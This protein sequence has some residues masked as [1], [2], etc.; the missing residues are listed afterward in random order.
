MNESEYTELSFREFVLFI[1]D[2]LKLFLKYWWAFLLVGVLAGAIAYYVEKQ[3]YILFLAE[4][5]YVV[6]K[7][8]IQGGGFGSLLGQFGISKG[9]GASADKII[10]ISQSDMIGRSL[11][12]DSV[13]I[14]GRSELLANHII[15]F[16]E[17][18]NIWLE[19]NEPGNWI[20]TKN[21]VDDLSLKERQ[22]IKRLV[23]MLY[24]YKNGLLFFEA[25]GVSGIL[26]IKAMTR[27]P[28]LSLNLAYMM[29][30]KIQ[31]FYT[32]ESVGETED[33][34][35]QLEAKRDSIYTVLLDKEY[36]LARVE[37]RNQNILSRTF[38]VRRAQ[39]NREVQYLSA[40]YNETL[41][42][43]DATRFSLKA[44]KPFFQLLDRPFEPLTPLSPQPLLYGIVGFVGGIFVLFI[45]ISLRKFYLELMGE[46]ENPINA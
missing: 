34:L 40:D 13:E 25:D 21:E 29:Y 10:A 6:N 18:N 45:I 20:I 27:D 28:K 7:A 42:S 23:A 4:I 30:G 31:E 35:K 26:T 19:D 14:N 17:L 12:L 36:Q 38:Q 24:S 39:L 16:H 32:K 37:D 5:T 1:Q 46:S 43:L 3:K 22:L 8:S 15:E 33:N 44:K 9:E 41:R 2:Y 11:L